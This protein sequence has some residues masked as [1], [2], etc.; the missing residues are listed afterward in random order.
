[1]EQAISLGDKMSKKDHK[2]LSF[3]ERQKAKHQAFKEKRQQKKKLKA[4][5]EAEANYEKELN[6]KGRTTKSRKNQRSAH[7][8]WGRRLTIANIIMFILLVILVLMVFLV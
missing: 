1:M 3:V 7:H 2:P 8:L 5:Q 4:R 6:T